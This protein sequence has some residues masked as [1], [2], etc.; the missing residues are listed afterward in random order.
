MHF[1]L[2][3]KYDIEIRIKKANQI[4]GA[5]GCYWNCNEVPMKAKR[6]IYMACVLTILLWGAKT[7]AP[8]EAEIAKMNVF[9]HRSI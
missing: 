7:W 3:D 1:S 9:H 5:L 4:M 2:K 8:T 6:H